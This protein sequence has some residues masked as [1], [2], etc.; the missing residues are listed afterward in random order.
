[1]IGAAIDTALY[2]YA[3]VGPVDAEIRAALPAP[4]ELVGSAELAVV[5]GE[6]PL[7][8][9]GED[10]LRERLND[11]EWLEEKARAHDEVIQRLLPLTTVVP[12]RFGSI[13]RDRTAVE[14]FLET[15]H[16]ALAAALERVRGRV[17]VGVK[18]WLD[19][20]QRPARARQEAAATGRAYLEQRKRERERAAMAATSLEEHLRD[21]HRRLLA[22]A[23]DG[24]VN[25]PQSSELTGRDAEMVLNAAYLVPGDAHGFFAE[26]D[27][28]RSE[29]PELVFEAT[30]PWAAYNFVDLGEGV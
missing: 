30:G 9:F 10:V 25:R 15:R 7:A 16:D 2:A 13:H 29:R 8:E 11:R 14:A 18:I 21:V 27:R 4:L 6:V 17:E 22:R 20:D 12:L 28:L 23:E 24:V 19:R 5:A 3:V 26:V 1:V